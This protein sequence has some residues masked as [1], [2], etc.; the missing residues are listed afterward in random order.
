MTLQDLFFLLYKPLED[1][2]LILRCLS[3]NTDKG[4]Q[5]ASYLFRGEQGRVTFDNAFSFHALNTRIDG[6]ATQVGFFADGGVRNPPIFEQ[7]IQDFQIDVIKGHIVLI[8]R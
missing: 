5:S 1:S 6:G 4:G 2:T 7:Q 8:S 3:P